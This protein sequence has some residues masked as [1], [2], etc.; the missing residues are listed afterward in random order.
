MTMTGLPAGFRWI[1]TWLALGVGAGIILMAGDSAH[2]PRWILPPLAGGA[3]A[4]GGGL[5]WLMLVVARRLIPGKPGQG[6]TWSAHV[7]A[8]AAGAASMAVLAAPIGITLPIAVAFGA[9]AGLL[10]SLVAGSAVRVGNG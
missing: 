6:V 9:V 4:A 3:G 10:G 2:L 5:S 1:A 8:T 7:M